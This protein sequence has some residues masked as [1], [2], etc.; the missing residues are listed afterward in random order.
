M[1][2]L[3]VSFVVDSDVD[4][5]GIVFHIISFVEKMQ[6][7][8]AHAQGS[9]CGFWGPGDMLEQNDLKG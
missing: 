3:L 1:L 9:I 7:H 5:D 2:M 6:L 8:R 4:L